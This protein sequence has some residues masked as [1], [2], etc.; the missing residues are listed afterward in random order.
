MT[1]QRLNVWR[2]QTSDVQLKVKMEPG[3][4]CLHFTKENAHDRNKRHM[5]FFYLSVFFQQKIGT[6]I[7]LAAVCFDDF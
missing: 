7:R 4:S 2:A 1:V 3:F 5:Y 6:A